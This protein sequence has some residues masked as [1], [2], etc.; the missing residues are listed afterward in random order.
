MA[1]LTILVN[2]KSSI[3][4]KRVLSLHPTIGII[5]ANNIIEFKDENI[6]YLREE[7]SLIRWR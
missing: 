6:L 1:F 7:S 3:H 5:K 2:T 4:W